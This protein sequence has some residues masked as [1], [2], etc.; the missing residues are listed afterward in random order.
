MSSGDDTSFVAIERRPGNCGKSWP[1]L[2]KPG[3]H[4][5]YHRNAH[6][7][8]EHQH[9]AKRY[10]RF[11]TIP[12][13]LRRARVDKRDLAIESLIAHL[14]TSIRYIIYFAV[15]TVDGYIL[16]T[17]VTFRYVHPACVRILYSNRACADLRGR[18]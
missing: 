12:S 10:H 18:H 5:D 17:I 9:D 8:A 11:W 2:N 14:H 13:L 15:L 7:N 6:V 1:G 3:G 4:V 16:S